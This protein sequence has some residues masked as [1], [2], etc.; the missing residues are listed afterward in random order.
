MITFDRERGRRAKP[1]DKAPLRWY[2]RRILPGAAFFIGG[3]DMERGKPKRASSS[4]TKK[5]A[6]QSKETLKSKSKSP[7]SRLIERFTR[8]LEGDEIKLS[9]SD[10]LRLLQYER[11]LASSE[12]PKE[13]RVQWIDSRA[14]QPV[15]GQ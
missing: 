14:D 13:V 7:I 4:T 12:A 15:S 2:R 10:Y 8:Q 6:R 3:I 9:V 11:D 5:T 1:D